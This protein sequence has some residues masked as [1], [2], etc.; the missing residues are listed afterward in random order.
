MEITPE[1]EA[2]LQV[3]IDS[4]YNYFDLPP[5]AQ[6]QA[7]Q[8]FDGMR[9]LANECSDQGQFEQRLAA[10]PLSKQYTDLFTKFAKY[11]KLPEGTPTKG[12]VVK[13]I[14]ADTA[15]SSA[16]PFVRDRARRARI[17]ALPDEISNWLIYRWHN[18]P[19]LGEIRTFFNFKHSITRWFGKKNK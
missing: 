18:I 3:R 6:A 1:K 10:S 5:Q 11:V 12:D 4:L 2:W 16:K 17:N 9:Q 7:E 14:V 19:V 8:V 13:G 15:A